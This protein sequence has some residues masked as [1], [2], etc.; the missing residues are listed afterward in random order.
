MGNEYPSSRR[1]P[2]V[3]KTA[4]TDSLAVADRSLKPP[5]HLDTRAK[6]IFRSLAG[7]LI[8]AGVLR[9][10][11]T[12]VLGELSQALSDV[13]RYTIELRK[14]GPTVEGRRAGERVANPIARLLREA[15]G[16]VARFQK[17]LGLSP[18]ARMH[19]KFP[20]GAANV[21]DD[22]DQMELFMRGESWNRPDAH[23]SDGVEEAGR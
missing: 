19:L 23:K 14:E 6:H 10:I 1:Q 8:L 22:S 16:N 20:S 4:E 17:E 11:D 3:P 7:Q 15:R 18:K 9:T 12:Y 2:K 21:V 5:P 13:Q